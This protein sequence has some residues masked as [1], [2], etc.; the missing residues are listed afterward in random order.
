MRRI[1]KAMIVRKNIL[2]YDPAN[3]EFHYDNGISTAWIQKN[4]WHSLVSTDD[5]FAIFDE[6]GFVDKYHFLKVARLSYVA[7][8]LELWVEGVG[9]VL[10]AHWD[11]HIKI[12]SMKCGQWEASYFNVPEK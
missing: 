2:N 8:K 10:S 5:D 1:Q 4:G 7:H 11:G 6:D 3:W 12:N 9:K